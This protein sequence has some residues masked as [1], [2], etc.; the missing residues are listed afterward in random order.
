MRGGRRVETR[1][2]G[3]RV[4]RS[5]LRESRSLGFARDDTA[6]RK[7][8]GI[9][10]LTAMG[11]RSHPAAAEFEMTRSD[12]TLSDSTGTSSF[13]GSVLQRRIRGERLRRYAANHVAR[14]SPATLRAFLPG[15]FD[16]LS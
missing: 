3:V 10:S 15:D 8:R 4:T 16:A 1:H 13:P 6:A 14:G 9:L 2:A 5:G 11:R 7:R 12:D